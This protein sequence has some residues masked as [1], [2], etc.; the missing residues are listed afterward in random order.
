MES[1][2]IINYTWQDNRIQTRILPSVEALPTENRHNANIVGNHIISL[3]Q[4]VKARYV[5]TQVW[6]N[7]ET[8]QTTFASL[9]EDVP[10]RACCVYHSKASEAQRK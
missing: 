5:Q 10:M 4:G 2:S 1:E 6:L 7:G 9:T 8:E 3:F